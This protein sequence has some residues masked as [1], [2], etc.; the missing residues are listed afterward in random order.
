MGIDKS[1]ISKCVFCVLLCVNELPIF[2][3]IKLACFQ[4]YQKIDDF[5]FPLGTQYYHL[6]HV[7]LILQNRGSLQCASQHRVITKMKSV[8]WQITLKADHTL[9]LS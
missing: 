5:E 4:L 6:H 1:K 7:N 9:I 2:K 3:K 8:C